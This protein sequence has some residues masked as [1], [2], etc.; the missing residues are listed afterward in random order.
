MAFSIKRL[1]DLQELDWEISAREESL[2]TVRAKLADDSALTSAIETL[3]R[4][5]S[6]LEDRGVARRKVESV[7]GPLEDKVKALDK[8]LYGGEVTKVREFSAYESERELLQK[9]R[10]AEEDKLLALMVEIEEVQSARGKAQDRLVRVEAERGVE[11]ADLLKSEERLAEE[12]DN[13]LEARSEISPQIPPSTLSV[14]E[15]LRESRNGH[16]VAKVERGMCQGC[17][18]ALPTMEAQRARSSQGI[19]QCS[20][21]RRIL[22]VV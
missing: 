3:E 8:R 5:D 2:A 13:L 20:S 19:A 17:R 22:Y 6:Q 1:Y 21:C 10:G 18:I 4:L 14:Y 16:A 15:S 7:V 9:R 12:L 11:R